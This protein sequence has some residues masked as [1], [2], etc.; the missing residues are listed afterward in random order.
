MH[1]TNNSPENGMFGSF[2][3]GGVLS[4]FYQLGISPPAQQDVFT[5]RYVCDIVSVEILRRK[6][7]SVE[8]ARFLRH[9]DGFDQLRPFD[10]KNMPK[11]SRNFLIRKLYASD[12]SQ[13]EIADLMKV[14]QQTVS[15]VCKADTPATPISLRSQGGH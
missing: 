11:G 15:N 3:T 13:K 12:L 9:G 5:V 4:L 14:T 1:H 10:P 6:T 2:F 8:T 7:G